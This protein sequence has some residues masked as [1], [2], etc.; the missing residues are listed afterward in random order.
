MHGLSELDELERIID[1]GAPHLEATVICRVQARDKHLPVYRITLGNPDPTLPAVGCFGGVHG[2]ERIGSAVV[3]A[4]LQSLV[5]RLR[6]DDQAHRLLDAVRMVFIPIVNP[7]G[8]WMGTRCNPAGVDLMRNAPVTAAE[9]VAFMV[10]GHR[11]SAALP[12]YR[13]GENAPMEPE[14]AALCQLVEA[15]LLTRRFAVALDCHSGFGTRDRIWFPYAHTSTPMHHLAEVYALKHIFESTYRNHRYV[16][17]PQSHQYLTHGD[18]WDHLYQQACVQP[19]RTF[20]PLTLEMGSWLWVKKNPRQLLMREGMFNPLLKH[21][22]ARVL[23]HH[24]F[25]LDFLARATA[26]YKR[27]LPG[28]SDRARHHQDA[29]AHWYAEAEQ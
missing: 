8:M 26:S 7:G 15:E 6:W 28:E 13:G 1:A 11:I 10:G 19:E 2:L 17:E 4:Y 22:I 25:L 9:R 3:I 23:R 16:F 18:L 24:V 29:L 12:W 20:L 21:R 14:S 5:D 27:W